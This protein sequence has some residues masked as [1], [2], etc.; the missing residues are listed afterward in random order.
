MD[1]H[2]TAIHEAGH[3]VAHIRLFPGMYRGELSIVPNAD[4]NQA[5]Y[6]RELEELTF[7]WT[8]EESPEQRAAFENRAIYCCA[9]YAVTDNIGFYDASSAIVTSPV[10]DTTQNMSLRIDCS[11]GWSRHHHLCFEKERFNVM[12]P[13]ICEFCPPRSGFFKGVTAAG[14]VRIFGAPIQLPL[15]LEEQL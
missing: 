9:G 3:A 2:K 10:Q 1:E 4:E 8:D 12:T 7:P 11:C 6:H 5:G 15:A 14:S 13:S